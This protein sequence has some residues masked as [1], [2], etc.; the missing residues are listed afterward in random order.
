M[1]DAEHELIVDNGELQQRLEHVSVLALR[2]LAAAAE[3]QDVAFGHH[4]EWLD[5]AK[6]D[7]LSPNV[8]S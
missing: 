1:S 5:D 2:A 4:E 8:A 6:R 7:V 3:A